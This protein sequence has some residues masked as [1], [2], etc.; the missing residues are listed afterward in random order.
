MLKVLTKDEA[1]KCI[2]EKTGAMRPE[3]EYVNLNSA[4]GRVLSGDILSN[5]DVPS[6]SRTVVDGFAVIAKDTFGASDS[7]PAQLETVGEVLMGEDT[8]L[9]IERGR[10]A[11]IST[12]GMLPKG[13]DAAVMV[14]HT[15]SENGLC[16]VYKAVS[17]NENI[18]K[19]GDDI[20]E[21]EIALK[22]GRRI[23]TAETAVLASL[24]VYEV[25]VYKKPVIAVIST[26]DELENDDVTAGKIRD[27]NSFMLSCAAMQYGCE[28]ITYGAVKDDRKLI[29][30]AVSQCLE[31]ADCVIISGGSSAGTRDMTVS[32]LEETGEVYFHG[33]AMKPGKP[34]IFGMAGG[35]PVF[36]LPGHPLAAY[37]V[38]R[39]VVTEFIKSLTGTEDREIVTVARLS[40]NVPSNNGREEY[41]CVKINENNEAVPLHTKSGI[42]SVLSKADGFIKIERNTEGL[43]KGGFVEVYRL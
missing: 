7:I 26:G 13:A 19:K 23:D 29:K 1:V 20:K 25:P 41:L 4:R 10:C 14:E 18:T 36:G 42:I 40:E 33:L 12:G 16:L 17:P 11:K 34:T 37:F 21:G 30:S 15:E 22:S 43:F 27:V 5:E 24:G 31:K 2:R 32:I 3:T 9:V 8:D 38:F 28:V 35:K 39:L 6:F